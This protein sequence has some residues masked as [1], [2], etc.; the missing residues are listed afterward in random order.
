M[1]L[2]LQP[3]HKNPNTPKPGSVGSAPA[4]A[5]PPAGGPRASAP[6]NAGSGLNIP[7]RPQPEVA[8]K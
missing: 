4:G 2:L 3:D 8:S 6:M 5:R 7:V 1:T